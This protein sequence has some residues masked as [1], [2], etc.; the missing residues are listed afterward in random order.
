MGDRV[1]ALAQITHA[2]ILIPLVPSCVRVDAFRRRPARADQELADLR[3]AR[4]PCRRDRVRVAG[5]GQTAALWSLWVEIETLTLRSLVLVVPV[6]LL[7]LQHRPA[8]PRATIVAAVVMVVGQIVTIPISG[9][10]QAGVR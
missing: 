8:R 10:I 5:H 9:M 3:A 6:G 1:R 7:V 4:A 2:P